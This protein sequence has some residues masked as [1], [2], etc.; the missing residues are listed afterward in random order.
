MKKFLF[1]VLSCFA[2]LFLGTYIFANKDTN[3]NTSTTIKQKNYEVPFE[4]A[5]LKGSKIDKR[6]GV[7]VDVYTIENWGD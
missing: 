3:P 1:A 2:L 7:K 4:N 6:T 5:V